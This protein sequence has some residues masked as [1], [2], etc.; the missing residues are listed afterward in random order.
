MEAGL[1]GLE[2]AAGEDD[3]GVE[4]RKPEAADQRARHRDELVG[5]AVDDRSGNGVARRGCLEHERRQLGQPPL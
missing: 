5:Q 1:F 4:S 3:L 2:D